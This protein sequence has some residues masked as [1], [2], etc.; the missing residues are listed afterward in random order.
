MVPIF[1]EEEQF[2]VYQQSEYYIFLQK[3]LSGCWQ[4]GCNQLLTLSIRIVLILFVLLALHPLTDYWGS[5]GAWQS[6]LYVFCGLWEGLQP[7]LLNYLVG[8]AEG[9]CGFET[10]VTSYLVSVLSMCNN[11]C[12]SW[13]H[14][15]D[16]WTVPIRYTLYS[17]ALR[18]HL[19]GQ[20][21]IDKQNMNA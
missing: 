15:F 14:A 11:C 18:L 21:Y 16:L 1:Q 12:A 3:S 4:G 2:S 5:M 8:G 6:S 9:V 17:R 19:I 10:T 13:F 7:Y 20:L